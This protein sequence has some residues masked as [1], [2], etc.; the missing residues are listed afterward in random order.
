MGGPGQLGGSPGGKKKAQPTNKGPNG[1]ETHAAATTEDL[2]RLQTQEPSLPQDPNEIPMIIRGKI[3]TDS[4]TEPERG[5]GTKTER[6]FY[7]LY[8]SE[9]SGS[10]SFRTLFP[11]WLERD[12]PNDRAS[13]YT[14]L[15]INRRS[16]DYDAD[17]V[18]PLFW[19]LRDHAVHTTIVGPYLH[20][21]AEPTADAP[22]RHD[23]WL[24]PFFYEGQTSDGG[25]YFHVP[26]LGVF[27]KHTAAR[28]LN[29][30]GPLFCS[31]RGGPGCDSR[32]ADDIDMGIAPFYFYG[33]DESSEY[34]VIPPLLHYYHYNDIGD[35][36]FNLWGPVLLEH[37][38]ES[39]VFN[40]MPIYWRN[41]GKNED[42]LTVFP[43]FHYGY[44]GASNLL[45]TPLFVNA[46]GEHGEHTFATYLY[47]HYKGRTELSMYTPFVWHYQ[48]PDI[49]LDRE[50]VFPFVYR[51]VSPRSNDLALFPLFAHF[52]RYGLSEQ[53]FITPFFRYEHDV[54]GWETDVL[55][56][57][58]SGRSY[59]STHLVLA[60]IVWDFAQA[61]GRQ[62]VIV[63][64]YYRFA[65]DTTVSQLALNTYYHEKQVTGGREWEFHFFPLFSYGESPTGHWWNV[66]YGLAGYTRES[67][68]ATMRMFYIPI[69]LSK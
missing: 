51:N 45:I 66:L 28:G 5:R 17:I 15:Y 14:P 53:T 24:S 6:S 13:M 30:A 67:T 55:P 39:D 61:H 32:T 57:F 12:Q 65:D 62:T 25:G 4:S 27:T 48:D 3:G 37:S 63:P 34:E 29:I 23:N 16:T 50:I 11:L 60:P 43:L 10:Y 22:G 36:S 64:A 41:W 47:A 19:R 54:T 2:Q 21:E 1:E 31:W 56:L 69:E 9:K 38:R 35:S 18:F 7:G 26:L 49:G 46:N 58:W 52:K 42:H 40:L 33:H 8:Y 44:K 68:A 20:R 59:T